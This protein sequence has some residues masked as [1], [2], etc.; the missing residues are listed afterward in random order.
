MLSLELEDKKYSIRFEGYVA[1][2]RPVKD[3]CELGISFTDFDSEDGAILDRF[4]LSS[5]TAE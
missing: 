2:S 5:E 4:F 1:R 3:G